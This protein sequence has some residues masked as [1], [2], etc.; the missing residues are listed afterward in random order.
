MS[1]ETIAVVGPTTMAMTKFITD[2]WPMFGIIKGTKMNEV[3]A[4]TTKA[5]NETKTMKATYAL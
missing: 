4:E 3:I 5:I 2:K 1:I